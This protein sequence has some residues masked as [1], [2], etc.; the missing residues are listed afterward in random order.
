MHPMLIFF[1]PSSVRK[2]Y[3]LFKDLFAEQKFSYL[4][5]C[6]LLVFFLSGCRTFSDFVR[7][8]PWSPSVSSLSRYAEAFEPNRFM[9]RN[10]NRILKKLASCGHSDFCFAVDDT[11]NPKFG[12]GVF[13]S[14]HHG[15]SSGLY[16][17]QKILVLVV[18]DLRTRKSYP[19]SYAFLSGKKDLN[20]ISAPERAVKLI[21]D[22]IGDGFPPLPVTSDSWF[23]SKEFIQA[24]HDLGCEFAGELKTNRNARENNQKDDIKQKITKWFTSLKRYR[25]SRSEHQKRKEKRG[26]AY[27]EKYL[28]ITGLN[29][30]LKI[31]AVYNRINGV[32]PFAIYATTDLSMT[33]SKLW[34]LSRARWSIE[35]LFRNL[36]QSLGFGG[37]TAG[38]EGGAHM[39][40]CLPLILATSIEL[41]AGEI[42]GSTGQETL[43][44]IVKKQLEESFGKAIDLVISTHNSPR[45]ER[46]RARRKNPN[47]KP[48]NICGN[49][50][51]A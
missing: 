33:G 11:A 12:S 25:L 40:V 49:K 6:S 38:S 24:V 16:F 27:S 31:I 20:H 50:K 42:W 39:A 47:Q 14:A 10:R 30:Q 21:A 28:Y 41:D 8:C 18:V 37:L 17:G 23:G 22:A 43:G 9:R 5:S 13:A 44:T 15:S 3:F 19:V 34:K 51:T 45:L 35:C 26:K 2:V 1:V 46:L 48:T 29:R 7:S 36:K 32:N 4:S